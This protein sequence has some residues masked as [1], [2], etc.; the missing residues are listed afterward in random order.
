MIEPLSAFAAR[1]A[2]QPTVASILTDTE[3]SS[4][5][6]E[7]AGDR[8]SIEAVTRS[9][10]RKRS[11]ETRRAPEPQESPKLSFDTPSH[12]R[13][14]FDMSGSRADVEEETSVVSVEDR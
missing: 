8:G 2:T 7:Q 5:A 14:D 10:K 12:K 6:N 11:Q 9:N 1:K 13:K 3:M 4:V